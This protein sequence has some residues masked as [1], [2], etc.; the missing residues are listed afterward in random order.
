[1]SFFWTFTCLEVAANMAE[2]KLQQFLKE[3]APRDAE[4]Y[5]NNFKAF[6]PGISPQESTQVYNGWTSYWRTGNFRP[7]VPRAAQLSIRMNEWMVL[8][9]WHTHKI[10]NKPCAF[11]ATVCRINLYQG[12]SKCLLN[13]WAHRQIFTFLFFLSSFHHRT[14]SH[15]YLPRL[16]LLSTSGGGCIL[17]IV[18]WHEGDREIRTWSLPFWC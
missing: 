12:C 18:F 4:A 11:T 17:H 3:R 10:P 13:D 14:R 16:V 6:R 2:E 7:D 8:C 15:S 5:A 1:M 9:I